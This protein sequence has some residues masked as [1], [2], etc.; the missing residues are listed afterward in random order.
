LLG[1]ASL[2]AGC[3]GAPKLSGGS[4]PPVDV[5][6]WALGP[7]QLTPEA[8]GD[9][10]LLLL[11]SSQPIGSAKPVLRACLPVASF[12]PAPEPDE[13]IF[14]LIGGRLYVRVPGAEPVPLPGDDPALGVAHLLAFTKHASPLEMIV[15]A[16]PRGSSSWQL[17][18]LIL[19]DRAIQ[20]A[21]EIAMD[22]RFASKE[23]FF[24]AY[25][26][27]RCLDGGRRCLVPRWDGQ[28]GYIEEEVFRDESSVTLEDLGPFHV[29]DAAWASADGSRMY[30]LLPCN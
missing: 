6:S 28:R 22:G 14:F 3:S 21:K 23:A 29:A 20:S 26:A 27:P 15:S 11:Q 30:L 13:R 19:E 2:S 7:E 9:R 25:S 17:W 10:R 24:D 5:I 8:R 4:H 16:K 18:A 12:L 1:L